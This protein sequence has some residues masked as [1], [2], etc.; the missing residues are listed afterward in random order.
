MSDIDALALKILL[1]PE[2]YR[3]P[4]EVVES[5]EPLMEMLLP[6]DKR[7]GDCTGAELEMVG[8]AWYRLGQLLTS[9]GAAA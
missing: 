2:K 6:N 4:D 8:Q 5:G 7:L 3:T 1:N 9:R